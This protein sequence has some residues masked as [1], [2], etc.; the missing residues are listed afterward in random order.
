LFQ[1]RRSWQR[2]YIFVAATM[3]TGAGHT[4]AGDLGRMFPDLVW[5]SGGDLHRALRQVAHAW[6]PVTQATWKQALQVRSLPY[7]GM[8]CRHT[9]QTAK[10]GLPKIT[11]LSSL[12]SRPAQDLVKSCQHSMQ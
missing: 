12:A 1:I 5:L 7:V 3:P 10:S 4:V 6:L 11:R 2:Q 9:L 8:F